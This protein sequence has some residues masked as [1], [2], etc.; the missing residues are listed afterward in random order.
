MPCNPKDIMV[1]QCSRQF[2][3][4]LDSYGRYVL[5]ANQA[6]V[7]LTRIR[8]T[9]MMTNEADAV[10]ICLVTSRL[11]RIRSLLQLF[12]HFFLLLNHFSFI[13]YY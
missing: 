13:L 4:C 5:C 12:A 8:M 2:C 7:L 9:G 1:L 3:C 11:P 6:G 10:L